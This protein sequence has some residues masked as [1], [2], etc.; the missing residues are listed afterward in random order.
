M[1]VP[2]FIRGV[3]RS[4][5]PAQCWCR[6][7]QQSDPSVWLFFSHRNSSLPRLGLLSP[8]KPVGFLMLTQAL[9]FWGTTIFHFPKCLERGGEGRCRH[10]SLTQ[11]PTAKTLSIEWNECSCVLGASVPVRNKTTEEGGR[12]KGQLCNQWLWVYRGIL[13]LEIPACL[14]LG[15]WPDAL[16][17]F[18]FLAAHHTHTHTD[19]HPYTH[20]NHLITQLKMYLLPEGSDNLHPTLIILLSA[21]LWALWAVF[22]LFYILLFGYYL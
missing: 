20:P 21:S 11:I 9:L 10:T 22:S 7:E 3:P 1:K 8:V 13:P 15:P 12:Q 2:G 4:Q 14:V 5:G 17:L 18:S 6:A 19:M 16:R